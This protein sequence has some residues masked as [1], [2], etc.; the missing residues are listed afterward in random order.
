MLNKIFRLPVAIFAVML[1]LVISLITSPVLADTGLKQTEVKRAYDL[2]VVGSDPEGVAAAVSGAR[3]GLSTLLVDTRPVPGGLMTLGWLNTIDMIYR[4]NKILNEG[5]FLE[6][7]HRVEGDSFDVG[8]AEAVFNDLLNAEDKLDLLLGVDS[9]VP[10]VKR[11]TDKDGVVAEVTGVKVVMPDGQSREIGARRVIDATQDA[12][13]AA[14]AGVPYTFGQEDLG[15]PGHNMAVT[16]VFKL[17]GIAP[18]DWLRLSIYLTY[19]DKDP[20]SGANSHSAWGFGPEMEGYRPTNERVAMRGLNLGR[21][22]DGSVLVN[23]LHIFGVDPEDPA[24]LQQARRLAVAEL[25]H[26]IKYL[27]NNIPGMTNVELGGVAPELYVRESRHILAEYRL[28]IDDVLEN[29]DFEDRIAFG[30]YPVDIQSTGPGKPGLVVGRPAQYAIPFRCLVPLQVD[31]LLVVGRSAG[32]DSLAHGS[33]RVIPVGMATGQAAGAA[34]ALSVQRGQGFRELAASSS[35]MEELQR[36]L[37]RQGVVLE[38]FQIV[39]RLA[40]HP[41][42]D[43]LKFMRSLGLADGGY[44]NDYRLDE[45]ITTGRFAELLNRA[46][47]QTG[48]ELPRQVWVN[49]GE[50]KLTVNIA[51]IILARGLGQDMGPYNA[52]YYLASKGYWNPENL[53]LAA[54]RAGFV[55]NGLAYLLIMDFI[56]QLQLYQVQKENED[57]PVGQVDELE[58]AGDQ[59]VDY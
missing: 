11:I 40:G 54:Q 52:S 3:S 24:S 16:L 47:R 56:Q 51:G 30:S 17:Q 25:P 55:S 4:V 20:Y 57:A 38:P 59:A 5:I 15:L 41:A 53:Q 29:R 49:D 27:R 37:Q 36:R 14:A 34:A 22:L 19:Q 26:I 10:L 58:W 2:V 23:A 13:L 43:G 33:A 21:Q 1:L 39:N 18:E 9:F 45:D 31:G 7:F 35:A 32:Y 8:T 50:Q 48:V 6:F 28:T 44:A 46:T 12:V 42:Y